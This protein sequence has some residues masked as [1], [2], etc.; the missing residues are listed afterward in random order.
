MNALDLI[1]GRRRIAGQVVLITGAARGIGA[2]VAR[3]LAAQGA[4]VALVGLEGDELRAV[5]ADCGPAAS[6]WEADVTDWAALRTAV[7]GIVAR[8]GRIDVLMANAGIAAAGFIRS[9]DPAAFERVVEVDL[10]GVWRTVRTCLPHLIE[11]RGYCLVVS[12][13]AAIAHIPG[14]APYNAAKAGVEAFANTL[15]AE[16]RH[17]GVAV[18]VAHPTWISTDMVTSADEHPVFGPLRT[19]M[20]AAVGRTYPLAVAVDALDSGIARRARAIHIP[21]RLVLVKAVRAL[22][23][24]VI[25]QGARR[26]V[27][28][29]DR[30]AL[31]DVA[32]RGAAASAPV[33]PGGAAAMPSKDG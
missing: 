1:R 32:R 4:T 15:R 21:A 3:R 12:S 18:G 16:V 7:D 9:I 24:R 27:P 14:N 6:A 30:A 19:A 25:E 22:L 26:I 29:A 10:L 31:D 5:A 20:P 23:P 13:M 8:H 11:S 28:N 2:G 17:L 33:G